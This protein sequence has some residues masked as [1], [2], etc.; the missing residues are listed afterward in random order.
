M[1]YE[2]AEICVG[3][4]EYA[5]RQVCGIRF[6]HDIRICSRLQP[7]FLARNIQKN[8][9]KVSWRA[10]KTTKTYGLEKKQISG[11]E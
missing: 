1:V 6:L 7:P 4:V 3:L 2:A 10:G 5:P 11:Y 8:E 9:E